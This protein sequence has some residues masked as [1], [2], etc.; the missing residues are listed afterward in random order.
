MSHI[1]LLK[2]GYHIAKI[3]KRTHATGSGTVNTQA[4]S[5]SSVAFVV[6][7]IRLDLRIRRKKKRKKQNK[8]NVENQFEFQMAMAIFHS[9]PSI[10]HMLRLH[11]LNA[12]KHFQR[13]V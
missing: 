7:F 1:N 6:V 2:C 13:C 10:H 8:K 11:V 4:H 5:I 3:N 9:V 12:Q